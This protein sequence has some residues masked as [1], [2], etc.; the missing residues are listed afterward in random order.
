MSNGRNGKGQFAEG[1]TASP[2]GQWGSR[3][4]TKMIT[5]RI[6]EPRWKKI[7]DKAIGQACNGDRSARDWLSRYTADPEITKAIQSEVMEQIAEVWQ[8][9]LAVSDEDY[10]PTP[11]GCPENGDEPQSGDSIP[12]RRL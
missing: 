2:G 11:A 5:E 7:I 10:E 4:W 6:T 9:A 8:A 12:P 3:K 1:N